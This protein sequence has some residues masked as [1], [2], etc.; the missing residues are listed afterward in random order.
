MERIKSQ[1][2]PLPCVGE[3]SGLGLMIGIEIVEDKATRKGFD[4][5]SGL[6][7][8]I[9]DKALEKGLFVRVSDES[10]SS[11][12]RISFCPPLVVT[13]EE[14]DKIIDILYPIVSELKPS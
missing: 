13:K 3:V 9:Q 8:D 7:H 10:W 2:L 12:N 14:V 4:P 11:A 5:T 6:M 1:F